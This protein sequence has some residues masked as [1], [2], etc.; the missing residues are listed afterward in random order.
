MGGKPKGRPDKTI[1]PKHLRF[2]FTALVTGHGKTRAYLH[3][4]NP[5]PV[6]FKSLL[7]GLEGCIFFSVHLNVLNYHYALVR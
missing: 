4:F 1:L 2:T 7:P 3:W 5:F 6:Q